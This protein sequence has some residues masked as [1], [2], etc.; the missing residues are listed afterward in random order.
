MFRTLCNP[1]KWLLKDYINM[2][3]ILDMVSGEK[4]QVY[5][6]YNSKRK[7]KIQEAKLPRP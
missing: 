3:N 1:C 6:H 7:D 5:Y 4:L 2:E